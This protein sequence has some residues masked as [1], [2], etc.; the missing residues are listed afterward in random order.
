VLAWLYLRRPG[1]FGPLRSALVLT[2]TG[3]NLVFWAWPV[4]AT[5][6]VVLATANHFLD[7]A[8]G[9]AITAL[10]LLFA[11]TTTRPDTAGSQP[12]IWWRWLARPWASPRPPRPS[13]W[14]A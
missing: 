14:R 10:G 12:V 8:A 13:A 11:R 5:T 3:A 6:L 1:A 2:T 4:A 7:A 9:L